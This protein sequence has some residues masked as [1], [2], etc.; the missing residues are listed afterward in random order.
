MDYS[1]KDA[2]KDAFGIVVG[3]TG[4][5]SFAQR[6]EKSNEN[7]LPCGVGLLRKFSTIAQCIPVVAG[8]A[9]LIHCS[10]AKCFKNAQDA[11]SN[12]ANSEPPPPLPGHVRR[13]S[14]S[15]ESGPV[16]QPPLGSGGAEEGPSL[17]EPPLLSERI[18]QEKQKTTMKK[19]EG[20]VTPSSTPL[21]PLSETQQ[22]EE[23]EIKTVESVA[24]V[25]KEKVKSPQVEKLEEEIKSLTQ[26]IT[27]LD[28]Q[29]K[30]PEVLEN[31]S[32]PM[33]DSMR[34]DL[35]DFKKQKET[36]EKELKQLQKKEAA[37]AAPQIQTP[38]I[39]P[40]KTSVTEAIDIV[41]ACVELVKNEIKI[42]ML[43]AE[44]TTGSPSKIFGEAMSEKRL[45]TLPEDVRQ[46]WLTSL[47]SCN[48]AKY[49]LYKKIKFELQES[50][51]KEKLTNLYQEYQFLVS[52][53]EAGKDLQKLQAR[54]ASGYAEKLTYSEPLLFEE[55]KGK[56]AKEPERIE[57]RH[58]AT[59]IAGGMLLGTFDGHTGNKVAE[60][61]NQQFTDRFVAA[62][63]EHAGNKLKAFQAV[64]DQI[65]EEI[66]KK[67]LELSAAAKAETDEEKKKELIEQGLEWEASGATAV[68]SYIDYERNLVY[69][70][71]AGDSVAFIFREVS[72]ELRAIPLNTPSDFSNPEDAGRLIECAPTF[73]DYLVDNL[74][75]SP[76]P[77][78]QFK[79]KIEYASGV[80]GKQYAVRDVQNSRGFGD[81][82]PS[83]LIVH[84][85]FVTVCAIEPGDIIFQSSDWLTAFSLKNIAT[86][87][88]E[89]VT[90]KIIHSEL[91]ATQDDASVTLVR[92]SKA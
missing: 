3:Y 1:Y 17:K 12:R 33:L 90:P 52:A 81:T 66:T 35:A 91:S 78:G 82:V 8:I 45:E 7:G 69:T 92:V 58:F 46:M 47:E 51:D 10:A 44:D 71:N 20:L 64:Y 79:F 87:I 16:V 61:V 19:V 23:E 29:L 24:V 18:E 40:V 36:K 4:M 55:I 14:S 83:G 2:A 68:V 49:A 74:T 53:E 38:S 59:P 80:D 13:L 11:Q 56:Y 43:E 84:R 48:R 32:V 75:E 63:K 26:N 86:R 54:L 22:Q 60:Y 67:I 72:G 21:A 77:H 37:E 89:G 62:I 88:R 34:E 28:T 9:Y 41:K 27:E 50:Q 31:T 42:N 6:W 70:A 30:D 85:P 5:K 39:E 57:D 25:A 73:K 15:P 76:D 65:Q